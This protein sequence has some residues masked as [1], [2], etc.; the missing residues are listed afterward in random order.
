MLIT[1]RLLDSNFC[2]LQLGVEFSY[3][4]L[5]HNAVSLLVSALDREYTY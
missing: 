2:E 3:G 4:C 1:D 5:G